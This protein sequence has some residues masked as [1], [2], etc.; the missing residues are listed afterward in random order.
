MHTLNG[1][2][3]LLGT[4][5]L[6]ITVGVAAACK[7]PDASARSVRDSAAATAAAPSSAALPVSSARP[8]MPRAPG[9]TLTDSALVARADA[10]RL[11]GRDSGAI[12]M[13][14]ISDFQCPYCKMWH[15][16]TS[17]AVKREYV[18]DGRVRMAYL[19]LP[20]PQHP[21][22]RVEA[23]AGLCAAA[24]GKFW[25][26]AEGLFREQQ[27][28]ARLADV[29]PLLDSLARAGSLDMAEFARCRRSNAIKS[30]V[31]SD[32][33]QATRT[34]VRSTPSFLIGDFLLEGASPLATF[35]RA[36][37]TA[38]VVARNKTRGKR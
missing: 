4:I 12:W 31:E 24:Q 20:L 7:Q 37:D 15:D 19:N 16:S 10:G 5:A 11:M 25:P 33:Q 2:S 35:R 26:Y 14:V 17:A 21:H 30:L 23:E 29:K 38:L 36:I 13:I 18:D 27:K 3:R 34:G 28:V 6:V 32:I 8:P 9:D 22:A 1:T